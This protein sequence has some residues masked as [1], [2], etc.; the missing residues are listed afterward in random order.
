V[1][2]GSYVFKKKCPLPGVVAHAFNPSTWEAE[3]G[4]FLSLRPAWS[5]K[6]VPGQT[7]LYRETLSRKTKKKKKKKKD[8]LLIFYYF[9]CVGVLS[10]FIMVYHMCAWC[11][12]SPKECI[13]S[14]ELELEMLMRCH[15]GAGNRA[16]VLITAER[17][18]HP[19][20]SSLNHSWIIFNMLL[21]IKPLCLRGSCGNNVAVQ[22]SVNGCFVHSMS[23][24]RAQV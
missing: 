22:M 9:R 2:L 8:F 3:A 4:G 19:H 1:S 11:P 6:W 24:L 14:P 10:V 23:V 21:F 17:A 5:T 18:P 20:I 12:Q 15:V 16:S 7:G 13:T